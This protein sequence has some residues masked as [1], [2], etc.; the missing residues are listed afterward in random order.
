MIE[1][2]IL[3]VLLLRLVTALLQWRWP[4]VVKS[5]VGALEADC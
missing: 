4:D 3:R 1:S 2:P 5:E